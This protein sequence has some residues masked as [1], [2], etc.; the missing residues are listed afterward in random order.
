MKNVFKAA[1]LVVMS[2]LLMTSCKKYDEGG[3]VRKTEK[4]LVKIWK[5]EKY[6]RNSTDETSLLFITG[7]EETYSDNGSIYRT[8]IE[9]DGSIKSETGTWKFDKDQKKLYISGLGSVEITAATG[10]VSSSYYNVLKLDKD[11]FWYYYTNGSE[12]HEFHLIKK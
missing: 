2:V 1:G 10:T 4:N 6:I 9:A 8:Y 5:L 3:F 11:E 12:K 7:Y